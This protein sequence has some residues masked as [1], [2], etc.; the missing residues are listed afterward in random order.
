MG[1]GNRCADLNEVYVRIEVA[2]KEQ[3]AIHFQHMEEQLEAMRDQVEA[4]TT[5]LSNM[6]GHNRR[7][8][9]PRPRYLGVEDKFIIESELVNPYVGH[10][11]RRRFPTTQ[12]HAIPWEVGV[13]LDTLKFHSYLQLEEFLATEKNRKIRPKKRCL[14]RRRGLGVNRLQRSKMNL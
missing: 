1:R 11:V 5:Q 9:Q 14:E 10:G 3:P 7:R 8:R 13:N 6:G 12:A 4:L 2:C